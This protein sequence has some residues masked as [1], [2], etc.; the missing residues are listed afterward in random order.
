M[1]GSVINYLT[2]LTPR[3]PKAS[4]FMSVEQGKDMQVYWPDGCDVCPVKVLYHKTTVMP[5]FGGTR[6]A[7]SFEL[8][9]AIGEN[10]WY[11]DHNTPRSQFLDEVIDR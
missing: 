11:L 8:D 6:L 2:T 3:R 1:H 10:L 9:A 4:R 7:I 5:V